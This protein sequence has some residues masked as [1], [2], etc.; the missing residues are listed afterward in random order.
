[1]NKDSSKL[2]NNSIKSINAISKLSVISEYIIAIPIKSPFTLS[3]KLNA[4]TI[5]IKNINVIIFVVRLSKPKK[6]K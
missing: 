1:M 4:L 6:Y 5:T 2:K 3:I